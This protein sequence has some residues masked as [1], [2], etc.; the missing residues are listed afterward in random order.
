MILHGHYKFNKNI[1]LLFQAIGI[2]RIIRLW[3][4]KSGKSPSFPLPV[5]ER[6]RVR[7]MIHG[8]V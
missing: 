3:Y 2:E 1:F 8:R 6:G 5:G 7:G 4:G